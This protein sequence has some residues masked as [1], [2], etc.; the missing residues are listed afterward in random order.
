LFSETFDPRQVFSVVESYKTYYEFHWKDMGLVGPHRGPVLFPFPQRRERPATRKQGD[1]QDARRVS[2]LL[3]VL[4]NTFI[5]YARDAAQEVTR[6][7]ALPGSQ[8]FFR[9]SGE[10]K[11]NWPFD[12]DPPAPMS[13][14]WNR[15]RFCRIST[16]E[17]WRGSKGLA[18]QAKKPPLR[19]S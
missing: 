18:E 4:Y 1:L 2:S 16:T 13:F 3:S 11:I 9:L 19:V 15:S 12:A 5:S 8:A 6:R 17:N 10:W 7:S 14:Q